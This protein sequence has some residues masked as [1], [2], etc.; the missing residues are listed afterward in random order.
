MKQAFL[1]VTLLFIIGSLI[2]CKQHSSEWNRMDAAE[3]IIESDPDSALYILENIHEKNLIGDDERARY[4]LLRSIAFDKS[5]ID[6]TTFD[7]LQPAID[8]YL[9][10]G[11]PDE[12]LRTYYYQGRIYQ[13]LDNNELAMQSFINA[14]DLQSEYTDTITFARMLVAQSVIYFSMYKTTEYIENNLLAARLFASQNLTKQGCRSLLKSLD[15]C[16]LEENKQ[17]ADSILNVCTNLVA[18]TPELAIDMTPYQLTYAIT[19]GTNDDINSLLQSIN[20]ETAL[21]ADVIIDIAYWYFNNKDFANASS[22]IDMVD[23][24]MCET[25][26]SILK[27]LSLK[28]KILEA[29]N[30]Y[31]EALTTYCDYSDLLDSVH[32]NIFSND[33]LFAQKKHDVELKAMHET[34]MRNHIL[35]LSLCIVLA[36]LLIIAVGY[37]RLSSLKAKKQLMEHEKNMI[38]LERDNLRLKISQLE[39]ESND[40]KSIL[41]KQEQLSGPIQNAIKERIEMLNGL[42]AEKISDNAS[43]S[44]PYEQWLEKMTQDRQLFMDS[45]RLAF[46]ASHPR[47]IEYLESRNLNNEE[48]NYL[49]LYAIGLKGKEVGVYLKVRRHY[50]VSSEI[51]KKLGIDEHET[52]IGI[53]VRKLMNNL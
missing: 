8:Y 49:C 11:T 45:T 9:E 29:T 20:N 52:N 32:Q 7:V 41:E 42:L 22:F 28:S 2:G 35:W 46:K 5:Y 53:Y 13:N 48:I 6:T 12:K 14:K 19:F 31:H 3:R 23:T 47:F 21:S 1:Y 26:N 50:N 18:Q 15:G 30:N 39:D 38:Q 51:R 17:R 44:K 25:T 27:Y 40:L 43:Y 4:A 37:N 36:L 34:N 16:I 24:D 33:L 10:K